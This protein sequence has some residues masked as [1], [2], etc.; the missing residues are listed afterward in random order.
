MFSRENFEIELKRYLTFLQVEKGLADNTII[1][2]KQD[3]DKFRN[4]LAE[5]KIDFKNIS[6]NQA[7]EYVKSQAIKGNSLTTQAHMISVLKSFYRYLIAEDQID[8]NPVSNIASPKRWQVL[9]KYLT[10]EQ[11]TRL[12]ECPDQKKT[13]GQRDKAIIELMYATGVR[14]SEVIHLKNNHVY[15][16][17]K[18]G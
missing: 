3:L 4:Y 7:I 14:I 2:Y 8:Y 13:V 9:P 12:L 11:V 18:A 1:S 15:M 6:E 17:W 5:K 16:R 10:I